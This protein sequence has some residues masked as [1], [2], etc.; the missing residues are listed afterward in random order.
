MTHASNQELLTTLNPLNH[1][2]LKNKILSKV[3]TELANIEKALHDNLTPHFDLISE[4][5]GHILFSGGKRLRPLLMLLS[6]RLCSY[7]IDLLNPSLRENKI[8]S[9]SKD[10]SSFLEDKYANRPLIDDHLLI[11][12][13]TIFEYLHTATLL[14]DDV[15]DQAQM[16]RGKPTAHSCWSVPKVVLAGDFMLARSLSLAAKTEIPEIISIMAGIT[17]DMS[18]GEIEQMVQ[19]GRLNLTESQYLKIIKHKTAVLIQ[20]ACRSGAILAHAGRVNYKATY[21]NGYENYQN[22]YKSKEQ[23]L[24][25]TREEAFERE[26]AL[27]RYGYHLGI[28]FQM[29]DDLL[30]Y[31]GDAAT[32]G[33]NPGADIREGKLTLPLIHALSKADS[34]DR[35]V[36][37]TIITSCLN[38]D[39]EVD[40][41]SSDIDEKLNSD[42]KWF[43]IM[44]EKINKYRGIEYTQ[45]QATNHVENAKRSLDLFEPCEAKELLLMLADYSIARKI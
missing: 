44:L 40:N 12:F 42:T 34:K 9:E 22:G 11:K 10:S 21:K 18:Q 31:T 39:G 33:K 19:K 3:A 27:D 38:Y 37:E 26:D 13:S 17:E 14:H 32:L 4:I 8:K 30:D 43:N 41:L 23:L 29:A 16:R 28:A 5:A 2:E 24:S 1:K 25:I 45:L 35:V 7:Q 20:G 36:M 15:V 6:S